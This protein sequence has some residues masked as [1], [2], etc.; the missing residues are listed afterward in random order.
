[1]RCVC[2]CLY[3]IV[4]NKDPGACAPYVCERALSSEHIY[5]TN[6]ISWFLNAN[7]NKNKHTQTHTHAQNKLSVCHLAAVSLISTLY[8]AIERNQRNNIVKATH[9]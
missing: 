4:I 8:L 3:V 5:Y 6:V 9:E 7:T 2:V 1:M